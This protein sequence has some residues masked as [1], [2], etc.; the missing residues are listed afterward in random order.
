[1][2]DDK[3]GS[4]GE[5][6]GSGWNAPGQTC[7]FTHWPFCLRFCPPHSQGGSSSPLLLQKNVL[8]SFH[9]QL[10]INDK[11]AKG[12]ALKAAFGAKSLGKSRGSSPSGG[13]IVL[14]PWVLGSDFCLHYSLAV[15][16][17]TTSP[18]FISL[19][20]ETGLRNSSW[21]GYHEDRWDNRHWR[22]IITTRHRWDF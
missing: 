18:S 11:E 20:C 15:V 17:V 4:R 1:M 2:Q 19:T 8:V 16:Q 21:Q 10:R 7:V 5:G 9:W 3:V 6:W 13:A 12:V 14:R 22:H